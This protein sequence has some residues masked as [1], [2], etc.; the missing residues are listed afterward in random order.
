VLAID[1][2][3]R[4]RAPHAE[5][6]DER[7]GRNA[8]KRARTFLTEARAAYEEIGMPRHVAMVDELFE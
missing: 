2:D 5:G 3:G 4:E 1:C 6:L 7:H 8:R